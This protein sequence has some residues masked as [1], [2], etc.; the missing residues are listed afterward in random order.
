MIEVHLYGKLRR[1]TDNLD[2]ACESIVKVK[3][4]KDDTIG[5]VVRRIGIP[6]NE[7]GPNIFLNGEY[8]ALTRKVKNGDRLGL[9]PDDMQ[10]LYKWYFSKV[11]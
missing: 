3:T 4:K 5:D 6:D 10:L 11:G 8:S 2:P 9:F 7:L 1:F